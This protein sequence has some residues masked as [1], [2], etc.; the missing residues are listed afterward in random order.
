M[1]II[2]QTRLAQDELDIQFWE[3]EYDPSML[4]DWDD[5]I[6]GFQDETHK[7]RSAVTL[8]LKPDESVAI[9]VLS[10]QTGFSISAI[11][12]Y[13]AETYPFTDDEVT[14][15]TGQKDRRGAKVTSLYLTPD[16]RE[17]HKRIAAQIGLTCNQFYRLLIN[18]VLKKGEKHDN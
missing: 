2:D 3:T 17:R 18:G 5:L 11:I 10:A 4:D 14:H 8:Y 16:L 12:I 15:Y 1:T 13:A 6:D 7:D 9:K